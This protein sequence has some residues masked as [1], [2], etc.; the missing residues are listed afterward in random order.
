MASVTTCRSQLVSVLLAATLLLATGLT[1]PVFADGNGGNGGNSGGGPGKSESAP[2]KAKG[3][4]K[5]SKKVQGSYDVT[6]AGY[7]R[8]S[9]K[10]DVTESDIRIT[11]TV[12]D[13]GG[14]SYQL[15]SGKLDIT[16]DRFH[17][18]GTL[19]GAGPAQIDG[20]VDPADEPEPGQGQGQGQG[21]GR[22]P[23]LKKAR[24][25]FTFSADGH[26]ARGAGGSAGSGS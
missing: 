2:G 11:A 15:T 16:D 10:A 20:R 23:V 22:R 18:E 13:P 24:I 3:S 26:R 19:A 14:R 21:R 17:G 1:A 9:G 8:G 6:I 4:K 12:T 25:M 5:P 7:Y